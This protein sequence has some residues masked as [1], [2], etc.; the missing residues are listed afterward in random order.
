M[1]S[2]VIVASGGDNPGGKRNSEGRSMVDHGMSSY[3][4]YGVAYGQVK[5]EKGV[6][7]GVLSSGWPSGAL[8]AHR[9]GWTVELVIVKSEEW[10]GVVEAWLPGVCLVTVSEVA[11]SFILGQDLDVW[12]SDIDPPRKLRFLDVCKPLVFVSSRRLRQSTPG[13]YSYQCVKLRH[14][15]CGGVT[16]SVWTFYVYRRGQP[17]DSNMPPKSAGRDMLSIVNSRKEGTPCPPPRDVK[18]KHPEVIRLRPNTYHSEG[19]YPVSAGNVQVV[20]PCVFS[21]TKWVRRKLSGLEM[22]RVKDI[23]DEVTNSL[24]SKEISVIVKDVAVVPLKVMW[25]ILSWVFRDPA[26]EVGGNEERLESVDGRAKRARLDESSTAVQVKEEL[27]NGDNRRSRNAKATKQDDAEIPQY[28]WDEV[29]VPDGEEAR[30]K[31][32]GTFRSLGLRWVKRR[33]T[34]E[35]IRWFH[36]KHPSLLLDLEELNVTYSRWAR[37]FYTR[38]SKNKLAR[39]EWEA[40]RECV[41][42]FSESTWWE[43]TAG[44]RPHYWRW[45]EEYQEAIRDGVSPWFRSSRPSWKVPQRYEKDEIIRNAVRVKL[46][47]VRRLEYIK[48]G[49]VKSLTSYFAVPKGESDIRMVYDGSKSGLNDA[50][51][52][53]WFSLPTIEMH[54]RFVGHDSYMGDVDIGDMFHNFMLHEVVQDLAGIDL[55]PFF[56]DEAVTQHSSQTLWERWVRSAMGLKSSPYNAIQGVL[57]AEEVIRGNPADPKNVFRWDFVRLNLP[58]MV[59]YQTH[60][61]WVSKVRADD[62]RVASDFVSYVDD[63]RTCG[64][65]K[66]EGRQASRTVAGTLNWLGLQDAARKRRE[67][68]RE[69]GPWAGAVVSVEAEGGIY[70]SV[71]QERWDKGVEIIGWID[72]E[73]KGGDTIHFRTLEKYRGFLI[74]LS[75]TYPVMTPFMKGIHLSLD[76]WRPWRR[77]DSWKMTMSEIRAALEE[78]EGDSPDKMVSGGRAPERVKWAPRLVDDLRALKTFTASKHPPRRLVRPVRSAVAVYVFGDASGSGFGSSFNIG[79]QVRYLSGQWNSE[80]GGQTSNYRE[81]VNLVY[82]LEKARDEGLLEGTE[83]FVFTDNTTAEAAF[84]KGTSSTPEL[85]DLVLRMRRLQ[86]HDKTILHV[87]HVAGRRMIAQGTDGLSRGQMSDGAMGGADFLTFVPLHLSA[88]DRQPEPLMEW[89][90]SWFGSCGDFTWLRPEHWFTQGQHMGRCVWTPA[91]AAAEAALEQLAKAKHK[92]PQH[93]HLVIIPRLMTAHW[94]RLMSK[95]CDLIFTVPT[96]TD[97][98]IDSQYEPLVVGL[99]LPLSRHPPWQLKGTPLLDGVERALRDLP[100]SHHCW[101]RSILRELLQRTRAL[102][103]MSES[104]VRKVLHPV[105]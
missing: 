94:R 43:W 75:R 57:F 42:R 20:A 49:R 13:G 30:L 26:N 18:A 63:M 101:G 38:L 28:L 2:Q 65:S 105:G 9:L 53:P 81:L 52:V 25:S 79:D 39:K 35:F 64:N 74:Y 6:T 99:S 95:I 34:R 55:T 61:P 68:S 15:D 80:H 72:K 45:P 50:M 88:V 7:C 89:V 33:L 22:C 16:D 83:V 82:A 44:S 5:T 40:G 85:F 67:P 62:N 100:L 48:P 102:E 8:A 29:I 1:R 98:W 69:P 78:R 17:R 93:T 66:E 3:A 76:S 4:K 31:A 73:V 23:P 104:L 103:G 54:M 21:P 71:T 10:K 84:F 14:S 36:Q 46:E 12:V 58:G 96:G 24:T 19:L 77:E 47:K 86:M 27:V 59:D 37:A 70:L 92:R 60:L 91:P 56:L 41:A 97:I 11:A 90:E 87:T 51:W 32:L